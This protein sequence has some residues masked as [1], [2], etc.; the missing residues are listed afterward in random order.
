MMIGGFII[1]GIVPKK[2]IVRGIGPSLAAAPV[3]IQS[4]LADPI[5]E[6]HGPDGSLIRTNDNRKQSQEGAIVASGLARKD[7][8][9]AAIIAT[10]GPGNYTAVLRGANNS[11]GVGLVEVYDLDAEAASDLR[12]VSTRGFVG[13]GENVMIGGFQFGRNQGP[14]TILV[15]AIGPNLASAGIAHPLSDPM[16][17]LHDMN[18]ALLISNDNWRTDP[19]QAMAI[20][21]TQIPLADDREAAV[22]T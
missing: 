4:P 1:T 10:L 18:G 6:L 14:A 8:K 19:A 3:N 16:L 9:E 22:I 20:Q 7:N 12:N 21:A 13:T 5:V 2:V 17:E 11:T 15:R